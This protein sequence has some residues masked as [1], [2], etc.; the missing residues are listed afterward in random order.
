[1]TDMQYLDIYSKGEYPAD[2][3]SNFYPNSFAF[4][5]IDCASMEG[6]LQSLKTKDP[7]RQKEICG[8]WGIQAKQAHRHRFANI[9][10]KLTGTLYW[11]GKPMKRSSDAYQRFLDKAYSALC[12]NRNFREALLASA[13]RE[14]TH[15]IGKSDSKRTVLTE[16]EFVTR[17]SRY[18]QQLLMEGNA[19]KVW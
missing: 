13:G 8:Y 11:K 17:L 15:K 10:W 16:Y 19:D 6:L 3:L 7:C 18:R 2:V 5:G 14:L 4:D 12:S 1:M 9:G